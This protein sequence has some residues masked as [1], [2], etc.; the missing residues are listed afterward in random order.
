MAHAGGGPQHLATV[1]LY[2]RSDR[3]PGA[4][5][6]AQLVA[7]ESSIRHERHRVLQQ[8][9]EMSAGDD[10]G[11]V[12]KNAAWPIRESF[13]QPKQARRERNPRRLY[14]LAFHISGPNLAKMANTHCMP[15][16]TPIRM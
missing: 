15:A 1:E 4:N 6:D 12:S 2:A 9:D 8:G 13:P 11:Q 3:K 14:R 10:A 16:N 7:A 5:L